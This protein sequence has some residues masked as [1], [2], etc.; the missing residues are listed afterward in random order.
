LVGQQS[1]AAQRR[2]QRHASD[3]QT[4]PV[5]KGDSVERAIAGVCQARRSD[6][7]GTVPIDDMARTVPVPLTDTRVIAAQSHAQGLLASAKRLV[8]FAVRRVSINNGVEPLNLKW[9]ITRVQGVKNIR[10]DVAERDNSAWRPSEPDTI[11]FGTVFLLGLR[12]DEA[13]IAVLAHELTHAINGTDEGLQ[14]LFTRVGAKANHGGRRVGFNAT[15]ELTCELVGLE[16]ARDYITQ[17]KAQGIG[18]RQRL[19]RA[20]QKDCVSTDMGDENHLSPRDTM[21][22]LLN[23]QPGLVA[24]LPT[25]TSGTSVKKRNGKLTKAGSGRRKKR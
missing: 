15:V 14:P 10:L 5:A 13:M 7:K 16:V 24:A 3:A 12:S 9:M 20:L 21:R 11:R 19:A 23:L 17:T 18:S 4:T 25:E 22:T 6:V 1:G 2:R 8:P